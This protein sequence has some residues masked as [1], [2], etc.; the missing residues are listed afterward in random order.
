MPHCCWVIALFSGSARLKHGNSHTARKETQ[1]AIDRAIHKQRRALGDRKQQTEKDAQRLKR[2][3]EP[4]LKSNCHEKMRVAMATQEPPSKHASRGGSE[5]GVWARASGSHALTRDYVHKWWA[6]S[7]QVKKGGPGTRSTPSLWTAPRKEQ[8][9]FPKWGWSPMWRGLSQRSSNAERASPRLLS[10]HKW[11]KRWSCESSW[12][13][14]MG[15]LH[16]H[17]SQRK[18]TC[19]YGL[20]LN[21]DKHHMALHQQDSFGFTFI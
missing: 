17:K 10:Q 9:H 2:D 11:P 20:S 13:A 14:R 3:L 12:V 18:H 16:I 8:G 4:W 15:H 21:K 6:L 5:P 19:G 7:R 1:R